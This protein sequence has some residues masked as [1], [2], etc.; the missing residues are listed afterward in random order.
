MRRS[1]RMMVAAGVVLCGGVW[2]GAAWAVEPPVTPPA[3][4]SPP[5]D[6]PK[7]DPKPEPKSEA[8]PGTKADPKPDPKPEEK[9]EPYVLGFTVKDIE[10]KEQ[11]LEQ[12]K[13]KVLVIINVASRC[14]YTRGHYTE[15]QALYEKYKSEGLEILAFPANDFGRQEPGSNADIKE[16]CESQYSVTFPLF[17]KISVKGA[18]QHPLF[19][20]LSKQPK[21]IGGDP[22]WNF[23][24]WVVDRS[25]NVVARFEPEVA[26]K[27][28]QFEGKLVELLKAGAAAPSPATGAK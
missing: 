10:G 12:Y 15:L 13:G 28:P 24:K 3:P 17:E 14:G 5:T 18:E 8:K 25:G 2:A 23:T 1:E 27:E 22:R 16:F 4:T 20:L 9:I 19:K 7:S 26:P 21:P 6:V 11:K